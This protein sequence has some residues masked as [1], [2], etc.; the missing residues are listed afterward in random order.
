M[1]QLWTFHF[2]TYLCV[3]TNTFMS[4]YVQVMNIWKGITSDVIIVTP[5]GR[6]HEQYLLSAYTR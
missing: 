2:L 1:L 5:Y 3:L 4:L 6:S